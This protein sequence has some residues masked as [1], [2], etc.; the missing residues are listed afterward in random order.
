MSWHFYILY[1]LERLTTKL[2]KIF[3]FLLK[4]DFQ[5]FLSICLAHIFNSLHKSPSLKQVHSID[6][7]KLFYLFILNFDSCIYLFYLQ[8]EAKPKVCPFI[9]L[10]QYVQTFGRYRSTSNGDVFS[11]LAHLLSQLFLFWYHSL[12]VVNFRLAN[13]P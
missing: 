12:R 7:V 9:Y 10:V 13:S 1:K 4:V 8:V 6:F 2:L 5:P 3:F 11:C